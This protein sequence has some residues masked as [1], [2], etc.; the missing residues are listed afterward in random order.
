MMAE[1]R[2]N[3]GSKSLA[4]WDLYAS[5]GPALVIRATQ[6]DVY[7]IFLIADLWVKSGSGNNGDLGEADQSL[8]GGFSMLLL[9]FSASSRGPWTRLVHAEVGSAL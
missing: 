3:T 6:H 9:P 2:E 1:P 5:L 7:V 8:G 4:I